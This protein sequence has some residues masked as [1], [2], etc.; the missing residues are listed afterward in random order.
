MKHNLSKWQTPL[1]DEVVCYG[2]IPSGLGAKKGIKSLEFVVN[3]LG[4]DM[5]PG[6]FNRLSE[7]LVATTALTS[8]QLC[9]SEIEDEGASSKNR[10]RIHLPNLKKL[11]VFFCFDE[12]NPNEDGM[13]RVDELGNALY[14]IISQLKTPELEQLIV[15]VK[16]DACWDDFTNQFLINLL[17]AQTKS[18]FLR[19]IEFTQKRTLLQIGASS[20]LNILR[21]LHLEG[22]AVQA[23]ISFEEGSTVRLA[24]EMPKEASRNLRRLHLKDC[25]V[26]ANDLR[27]LLKVLAKRD[28]YPKFEALVLTR[29]SGFKRDMLRVTEGLEYVSFEDE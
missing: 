29:C 17:R 9:I 2:G 8:L 23:G 19:R 7:F 20:L 18:P 15:T 24:G 28:I 4:W 26:S 12:F 11:D 25:S 22:T 1:L 6:Y 21:N 5:E 14:R 10:K 16:H 27:V 13:D 3:D